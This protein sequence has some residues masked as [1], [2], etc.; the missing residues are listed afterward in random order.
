MPRARVSLRAV[1]EPDATDLEGAAAEVAAAMAVV[2]GARAGDDML[3]GPAR[4]IKQQGVVLAVW[5]PFGRPGR[6]AILNAVPEALDISTSQA[7][8]RLRGAVIAALG[9]HCRVRAYGTFG[10]LIA[11]VRVPQGERQAEASLLH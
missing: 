1:V 5:L 3:V 11:A 4:A 8:E 9:R 6:V 2:V 7:R 10:E